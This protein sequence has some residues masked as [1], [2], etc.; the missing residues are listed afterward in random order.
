MWDI[1]FNE[2]EVKV[3]QKAAVLSILAALVL[4]CGVS[5]STVETSVTATPSIEVLPTA[6]PSATSL[7]LADGSFLQNKEANGIRIVSYNV[8]WDSIFLVGDV[9]NHDLRFF[10]R[11]ESF[12][13]IMRAIAP[14]ILC[15]QE[16][17]PQRKP[18][19]L[20]LFFDGILDANEDQDWQ[21]VIT[22]D[23]VIAS[24][25]DLKSE[26]LEMS[27]SS[28]IPGLNQA[29][30]LIELPEQYGAR[31]LY[32]ICAHFQSG[33]EIIDARMRL[34]Q[35]DAL[36]SHLRDAITPGGDIDLTVNTQFVILGDF[37]VYDLESRQPITTIVTG[38]IDN[39]AI[40]GIDFFPDWDQTVLT[41]L[42]PSHN[43]LGME[44]YTWR[45]D[46][47]PFPPGDLDH[48]FFSDSGLRVVN[49]FILNSLQI[50]ETG[51]ET[52][53]LE[54][55]DVLLETDPL[56]FDHLP[57]VADFVIVGN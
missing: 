18:E 24:H 20:A 43:D 34:R 10:D 7:P 23:M 4:G 32:L 47:G 55:D 41:D 15:L 48:I 11:T 38:D 46:G 14:D 39:E 13:R 26:G 12:P 53:V 28:R 3:L 54:K 44:F 52:F 50:S 21:A 51:L 25:F 17:N 1:C 2:I 36:M 16:L 49:S 57:L 33:G 37:N 35:A 27:A 6:A 22:R 45:D 56:N 8:N 9:N 29:A 40:Y 19:D 31:D 5:P 42:N 30:A